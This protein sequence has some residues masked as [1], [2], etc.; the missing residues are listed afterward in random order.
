[1]SAVIADSLRPGL[2]SSRQRVLD[3]V[4]RPRYGSAE[5]ER[6]ADKAIPLKRIR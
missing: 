1:M 4:D 2:N 6:R 3:P 5:T